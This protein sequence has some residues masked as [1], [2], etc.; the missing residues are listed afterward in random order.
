M[1]PQI[2]QIIHQGHL[3]AEKCNLKARDCVFWP[4]ISKDINEM[5]SNCATCIQ[6]SK[7]QP[8][9]P[10]HPHC[11]PSF[12]WQKLAT[13][14]L[15]YQG[16]QYLLV[17]DYYSKYP[18]MRKLSSTTSTA[19]INH[20]KSIFSENGVPETLISDNGSQYN[21]Q[22]FAALCKQWGIDY[23]TSSPLYPQSNGFVERSVQTVKNLL[24]RVEASGQDPYLAL[25]TYRTT[26]VDSNLPSPSQLLNHRDYRTQLP[27]SGHLQRSQAFDSRREQLQNRQDTQRNQYDRQ[28][29]HTLRRLNQGEQVVVFQSQTK[30][31]I[32]VEV[33]E[34]TSK[35]RSYIVKTASGS[36]LRR[37]RVQLK[38]LPFQKTPT[39]CGEQVISNQE[40]TLP[41]SHETKPLPLQTSSSELPQALAKSPLPSNQDSDKLPRTTRSGR[42]VK[43]PSK[44]DL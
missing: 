36:E 22:E 29:I 42:I 19:V 32:A 20:L 26:P 2:L 13:D 35:P 43:E 17:T 40:S 18:I 11:V 6:F 38:P 41:D 37:N 28:G 44:L 24:R 10:L 4:G 16:A 9:E 3:G 27:C 12:P 21:F 34:E 7:R 1:R 33:K 15:D 8:K 23:V 5:A 30:E 39:T 25:L 31:W 14:L